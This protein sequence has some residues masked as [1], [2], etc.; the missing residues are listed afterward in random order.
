MSE[1]P[2]ERAYAEALLEGFPDR[3]Q[4]LA[5]VAENAI[6][7]RLEDALHGRHLIDLR[8][9]SAIKYAL[10]HLRILRQGLAA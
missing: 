3:I 6:N 10:H 7:D 1:Y 2:W 8:E 4:Q 5:T 9:R